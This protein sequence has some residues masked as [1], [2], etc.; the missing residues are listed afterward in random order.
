MIH[1]LGLA[2]YFLIVWDI[3]RFAR[4][5]G[6]LCQGRGSAANS[7]VCYCLGITAVDPIKLGLLFERF[8]SDNRHEA[9]DIDIDFAHRERER[10]IQYVYEKYGREHAAMV[11]EQITYRG[12]SAVRD[13]ARVLGFSVEQA[14]RLAMLSDRFSARATAE[15]LRGG[16]LGADDQSHEETAQEEIARAFGQQMIPGTTATTESREVKEAAKR[17]SERE[18]I[19]AGAKRQKASHAADRP[20]P[21]AGYEPYG[22]VTGHETVQQNRKWQNADKRGLPSP[23]P[24]TRQPP[25]YMD[26]YAKD[27]HNERRNP[28]TAIATSAED[29][30]SPLVHAGLGSVEQTRSCARRDRRRTAP[31]AASPLDSCRG[32]SFSRPSRCRRSSPSSQHRCR[33]AR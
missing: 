14:D 30:A 6:I 13:A 3:V 4:R 16:A 10:V 31:S 9:P 15:A 33:T 20:R 19:E 1:R 18:A 5:E 8:L 32:D 28:T 26:P 29:R 7:A 27:T 24:T 2:G 21:N 12:R 11:C 22:S 17:V 23:T 25:E